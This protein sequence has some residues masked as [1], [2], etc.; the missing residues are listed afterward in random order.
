MTEKYLG[1][2]IRK[3]G[4]GLMRLPTSGPNPF[5]GEIDLEQVKTMVDRFIEA[6]FTYFDTAYVYGEGKSELAIR[7]ALTSRYP[8]DSYQMADKLPLWNAETYDQ[9]RPLFN[10]SLE[11]TGAAYFDFYLQHSLDA[12]SYQRTEKLGSWKFMQELKS[13]GLIKYAG[14]SFHDSAEVLE[15]ILTDHPEADFVQLQI[16]YADWNDSKT[17]SRL[18]YETARRHGKP[19]IIMEPV[20]GGLLAELN[21]QITGLLKTTHPDQSLPS[22][23]IRFAASLDG[24]ITVLSGMSNLDQMTDNLSTMKQFKPLD[25]AERAVLAK[26]VE[27]LDSSPTVPCTGCKYC[28]DGCPQKINIPMVFRVLNDYSIYGDAEKCK[29]FY[30]FVIREA[31]KASECIECGACEQ[32]CPQHI[33]IIEKLKEAAAAFE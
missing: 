1:S 13:E 27:I 21:P 19:I 18:C 28:V 29:G 3:L 24:V 11:R 15:K 23:A 5:H 6:G 4:F 2:D 10:T 16:N 9:L 17:Q 25:E 8:R 12:D 20:K 7:D 14:F 33:E 30:G 32:I 26:V 22:W 31:G